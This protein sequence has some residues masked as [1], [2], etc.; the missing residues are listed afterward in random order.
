MN[1]I[2]SSETTTKTI[3]ISSVIIILYVEKWYVLN[4]FDEINKKTIL[5]LV[6]LILEIVTI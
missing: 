2:K 6:S 5:Y 3:S 1:S 4:H